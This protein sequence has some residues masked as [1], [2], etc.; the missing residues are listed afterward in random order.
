[1]CLENQVGNVKPDSIIKSTG[2]SRNENLHDS[3]ISNNIEHVQLKKSNNDSFVFHPVT[4]EES[5][6][7]AEIKSKELSRDNVVLNGWTTKKVLDLVQHRRSQK[8]GN[9]K[10]D[11]CNISGK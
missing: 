1:M 4:E 2:D 7:V 6:V 10:L 9:E 5:A 11:V 3:N 8:Q